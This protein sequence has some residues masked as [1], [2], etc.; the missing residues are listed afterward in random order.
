MG[1]HSSNF[2]SKL[3]SIGATVSKGSVYDTHADSEPILL[4]TKQS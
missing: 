4:S 1:V 2:L 3:V